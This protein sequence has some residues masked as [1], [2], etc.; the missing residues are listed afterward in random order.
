MNTNGQEKK[1]EEETQ[2]VTMTERVS[3]YLIALMI[4]CFSIAFFLTK[5]QDFSESENRTLAKLPQITWEK[6]RNGSVT[7]ALGTYAADHFPMRNEFLSII[8]EA[9][10]LSGRKE[11]NGVYLAQDGSLIEV[12]DAPQNTDKQ[13]AQFS[14]LAENTEHAHCSLMLVPTAVSVYRDALPQYA[15]DADALLRS[16]RQTLVAEQGA[17]RP[18]QLQTIQQIYAAMPEKMQ[19]IDVYG[20]LRA[21]VQWTA[22]AMGGAEDGQGVPPSR[23]LFYRTDHHWTVYG[24]YIGYQAWCEARGITPLPLTDYV[25]ETV[26]EDFRG[27]IYSKLNDPYFGADTIISCRHPDWRLQV[28]YPD[29]GEVTDSPYNPEYLTQKDQYSYFLNNIHP[30]VIITNDAVESGAVA[31]V[32]DSYA[33]CFVPFLL[34]HYHTVYVFDTR[35]YKGGPSKFINEHPEITEVL[36]LYN[37]NTIDSDTGIGGIY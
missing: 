9:E 36:V 37:M 7:E 32:K 16:D 34:N 6:I 25:T 26:S 21:D 35:Y 3:A 13:I 18:T 24:A 31:V 22:E 11:I 4:L 12:Y 10:R 5:K 28:L 19:T 14:K 15:P 17:A 1:T 30:M 8:T 27:T 33:N 29:T 2:P 20:A 23:R